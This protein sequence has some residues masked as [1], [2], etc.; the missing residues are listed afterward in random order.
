MG[1]VGLPVSCV[2]KGMNERKG[3]E[4]RGEVK[5]GGG[6]RVKEGRER[7][8]TDGCGRSAGEP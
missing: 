8:G 5:E 7:G 4:S 6:R 1:V 3:G 2:Q